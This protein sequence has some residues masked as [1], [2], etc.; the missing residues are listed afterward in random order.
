MDILEAIQDISEDRD[1]IVL[2]IKEAET[3]RGTSET[4]ITYDADSDYG[5]S[6]NDKEN[7][8]Y[9]VVK[10]QYV[11]Q[12]PNIKNILRWLPKSK[13][14]RVRKLE[15]EEKEAIDRQKNLG[16]ANNAKRV[17]EIV[18]VIKSNHLAASFMYNEIKRIQ[19]DRVV[20][21]DIREMIHRVERSKKPGYKQSVIDC[22]KEAKAEADVKAVGLWTQPSNNMVL[23]IVKD[24]TNDGVIG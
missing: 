15:R 7:L 22:Y 4:T 14:N 18:S 12:S 9:L 19:R 20:I 2:S 8:K 11:A 10:K 1:I 17:A 24:S 16:K 3:P 13:R 23:N 6:E 5:E 21:D